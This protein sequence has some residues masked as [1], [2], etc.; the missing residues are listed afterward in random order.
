MGIFNNV[1]LAAGIDVRLNLAGAN[2]RS[3]NNADYGQLTA[4]YY[5]ADMT[6]KGASQISLTELWDVTG[7][8][9]PKVVVD[10]VGGANVK[11]QAVVTEYIFARAA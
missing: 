2:L 10:V 9:E 7:A 3:K 8:A 5:V 1:Q 11:M 4:G 6:S